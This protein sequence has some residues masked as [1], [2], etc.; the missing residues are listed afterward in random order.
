MSASKKDLVAVLLD[1]EGWQRDLEPPARS[2]LKRF[3]RLINSWREEVFNYFPYRTTNAYTESTNNFLKERKRIGRG[4]DFPMFRAL[5]LY[6]TKNKLERERPAF[7]VGLWRGIVNPP[8][9]GRYPW[10]PQQDGR[11]GVGESNLRTYGAPI[12]SV[13]ELLQ[14]IGYE[15]DEEYDPTVRDGYPAGRAGDV[16]QAE[17]L[18]G[19]HAGDALRGS[20]VMRRAASCYR[21]CARR[22]G[23]CSLLREPRG[24]GALEGRGEAWC[25]GSP[26]GWTALAGGLSPRA[27]PVA[28][29]ARQR[30]NHSRKS[31]DTSKWTP[32]RVHRLRPERSAGLRD[33]NRVCPARFQRS[34]RCR[35]PERTTHDDWKK[36]DVD[37]ALGMGGCGLAAARGGQ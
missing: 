20:R 8:E 7:G 1:L 14:N 25:A 32:L 2:R 28:A 26:G 9:L 10:E 15:E 31:A 18:F 33:H 35:V 11:T 23:H 24:R 3:L 4:Y 36:S 30:V 5:A 12:S 16:W 6:G 34:G 13:V 17:A 19:L 27:V 21:L 22:P 29:E 37:E